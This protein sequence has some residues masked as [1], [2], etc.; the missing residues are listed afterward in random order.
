[1]EVESNDVKNIGST[2]VA[3]DKGK[4]KE[5][6]IQIR[7]PTNVV[8]NQTIM[9]NSKIELEKRRKEKE[10]LENKLEIAENEATIDEMNSKINF[11]Q[12]TQKQ[13]RYVQD[14]GQPNDTLK[15]Q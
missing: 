11:L 13:S 1:M 14:H 4:Y 7:G 2:D 12:N 10:A 3:K 5:I 6:G 8:Q 9:S 15:Q